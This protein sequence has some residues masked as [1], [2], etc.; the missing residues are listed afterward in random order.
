MVVKARALGERW[1][2]VMRVTLWAVA[3]YLAVVALIVVRD[4]PPTPRKSAPV[5]YDADVLP[6]GPIKIGER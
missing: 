3:A 5:R 2:A 4:A 1:G 6:P